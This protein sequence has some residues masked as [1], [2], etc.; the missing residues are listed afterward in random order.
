MKKLWKEYKDI[1]EKGEVPFTAGLISED[2]IFEWLIA[3]E[4]P[5]GTIY[6]GALF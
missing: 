1:N 2:N 6:E 3:I 5:E 4:G